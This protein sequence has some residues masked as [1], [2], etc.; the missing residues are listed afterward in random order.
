M[1]AGQDD[2]SR[3]LFMR[4]VLDNRPSTLIHPRKRNTGETLVKLRNDV[5]I[6]RDVH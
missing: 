6:C 2:K 4:L 3:Q 1:G 5:E